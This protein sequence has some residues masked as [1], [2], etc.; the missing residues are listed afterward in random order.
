M[1]R[2]RGPVLTREQMADLSDVLD[3]GIVNAVEGLDL[4]YVTRRK[5]AAAIGEALARLPFVDDRFGGDYADFVLTAREV[6]AT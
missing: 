4:P 3:D 1:S 2:A 6:A 5:I